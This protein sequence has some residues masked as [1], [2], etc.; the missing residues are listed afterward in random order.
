MAKVLR[1]YDLPDTRRTRTPLIQFAQETVNKNTDK[2]MSAYN[3]MLLANEGHVLGDMPTP[4]E[5]LAMAITNQQAKNPG[6]TLKEATI[7]ALNSRAFSTREEVYARNTIEML[8]NTGKYDE[9]RR[10]S[11]WQKGIK[12][13]LFEFDNNIGY[14]VYDN[15]WV[16]Y[17]DE[18]YHTEDGLQIISIE[19]YQATAW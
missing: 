13:D 2:I 19:E 17:H 3:R 9:L 14:M 5:Y 16:I 10:L 12:L 1:T 7:K 4:A 15:K 11:G 8:K 18:D 6:I